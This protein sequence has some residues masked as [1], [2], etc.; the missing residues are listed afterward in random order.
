M[1]SAGNVLALSK[2]WPGVSLDFIQW[3]P[4]L[5]RNDLRRGSGANAG[6]NLFGTER[7]QGELRRLVA[8][9]NAQNLARYGFGVGI[10]AITCVITCR[11]N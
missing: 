1:G 5:G 11:Q 10:P 6:L 2:G 7:F 9:A 4:G 3:P 8:G